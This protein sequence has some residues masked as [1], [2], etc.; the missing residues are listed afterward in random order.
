MR[1][2]V[3]GSACAAAFLLSQP[4][5]AVDDGT[6]EAPPAEDGANESVTYSGIGVSRVDVDLSDPDVTI[7][8]AIN[9]V[10]TIGFRIPTVNGFGV[11]VELGQTIIPGQIKENSCSTAP[12]APPPLGPGGSTT[13]CSDRDRGDF[14]MNFAAG[15]YAVYRT[16]GKFYGMGKVGYRYAGTNIE[17]LQEDRTGS[18]YAGG[19]GYRWN[20][21]KLNGAE[22]YYNKF[23]SQ[24][25]YIGLSFSYGFGGRD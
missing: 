19:V 8:G 5:M 14:G 15:V 25:S 13:T 7:D 18:A 16:P 22:I 21:K 11:E 2:L 6:K 23:T 12:N 1:Q 17:E 10:A 4:V 20:P 3:L 9:L 24:I